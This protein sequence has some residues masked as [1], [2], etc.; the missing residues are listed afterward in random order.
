MSATYLTVAAVVL[1]AWAVFAFNR[2]VRDRNRVKSGWS[3]VDVQLK[4]R[5]DL[6]PRL[7]EAV[8]GYAGYERATLTALTA[9]RTE[10]TQEPGVARK[11]EIE[12]QLGEGVRRLV[13]VAESYPDLKANQQ[14]AE[15]ARDLVQVEDNI[16]YARRYYNGAV[17]IFN[18]RVE[19]FPDLLVAGAL[20]FRQAEFFQAEDEARAA[21]R[22]E[23][24]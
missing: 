1:L 8:K 16:Q 6:V 18:T 23:L 22:V 7:V 12:G 14:F 15:L 4:R 13:A 11:G 20:G 9:L 2:L 17:R 10:A 3:D 21:P 24:K 19:S 5:H